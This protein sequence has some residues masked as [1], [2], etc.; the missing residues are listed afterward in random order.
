MTGSRT[1]DDICESVAQGKYVPT[2]IPE[3]KYQA[4]CIA[5]N[6]FIQFREPMLCLEWSLIDP[7]YSGLVLPQYFRMKYARFKDNTKYGTAF[8]IANDGR[9]PVRATRKYMSPRVFKNIICIVTIE[10]V[11]PKFDDGELKPKVFE[12]SK[13]QDVRELLVSNKGAQ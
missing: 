8:I 9:R 10:T 12:Y 1:S 11:R 4:Q 3:G 7:P 13:V 5:Q 6:E 2:L